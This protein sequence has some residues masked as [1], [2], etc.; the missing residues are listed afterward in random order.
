M[1]T[2]YGV[3][4]KDGGR[5]GGR[6]ALAAVVLLAARAVRRSV[7]SEDEDEAVVGYG[8]SWHARVRRSFEGGGIL[9]PDGRGR[10]AAASDDAHLQS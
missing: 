1:S 5:D 10:H 9:I 7:P 2:T 4:N 3:R 8:T 6:L